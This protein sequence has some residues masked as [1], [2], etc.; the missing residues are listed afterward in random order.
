MTWTPASGGK[1][2]PD[3]FPHGGMVP[4]E[5]G[6]MVPH[7]LIGTDRPT[8]QAELGRV[9]KEEYHV[10]DAITMTSCSMCHR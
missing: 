7:P 3:D 8:S 9:L 10:R 5:V 4:G 1:W 2:K 6:K